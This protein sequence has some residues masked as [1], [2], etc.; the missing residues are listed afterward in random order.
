MGTN[1]MELEML[2]EHCG[3]EPI[4][5]IIAA[6][7]NGAKACGL[8]SEIGT[9]EKGKLADIIIVDGDPVT[10][11]KVLQEIGAIR[12]VIKEG[13]IEINRGIEFS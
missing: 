12:L 13:R 2:V 4:D 10:N 1:A 9:V 5:A 7:G 11:I 6:T 3:F 8:E